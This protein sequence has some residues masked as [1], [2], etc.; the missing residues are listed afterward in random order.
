MSTTAWLLIAAVLLAPAPAIAQ[1]QTSIS[2]GRERGSYYHIGQR[3]KNALLLREKL[4]I[5]VRVSRG[6][7]DN[8]KQ[9]DDP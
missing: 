4:L 5:D 8:L 7:L 6:S 2:T 1:D 3:L 9:L